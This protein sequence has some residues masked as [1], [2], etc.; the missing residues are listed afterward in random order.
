MF[1]SIACD[2]AL[3]LGVETGSQAAIFQL[4]YEA[5]PSPFGNLAYQDPLD[6]TLEA[7]ETAAAG[8]I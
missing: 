1:K 2:S 3:V 8:I 7:T 6:L 5:G 4:M